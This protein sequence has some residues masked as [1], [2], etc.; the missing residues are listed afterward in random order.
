MKAPLPKNE[1]ERLNALHRYHILDTLPEAEFDDLTFLAAQ[2]CRTPI[3]LVNF[4]DADRQWSKSK[5]GLDIPETSRDVSF[6]AH[7]ILQPDLFIVPDATADERFADNPLVT[8]EPHIRF[9]AAAPLLTPDGYA[10]GTLCVIDRRTRDLNDEQE[11]ALRALS[12]QVVRQLEL[13]RHAA[14]L[15]STIAER[16]QAEEKYHGIFENAVE[17]IYQT[18]LE[19]RIRSANPALARILGYASPEEFM[20]SLTDIARQIYVEPDRRA[21]FMRLMQEQGSVSGF[22]SQVYRKDGSVIWISENARAVRDTEGNVLYYEGFVEDITERK[23][24]DR[25]KNEFISTVSHELRT[26]LTA[27][28]GALGLIAG[29]VAGEIPAQARAMI[30]I[31]HKNSERLVR[32]INEIL[33]IERIESGHVELDLRPVELMPLIEQALQANQP[34]GEQFGIR[35]VLDAELPGAKVE[36]D[37]D[38]LMQVMTHLLANAAKFSPPNGTVRVAVA[39]RGEERDGEHGGAPRPMIRVTVTDQGPG[40]P[41]EFREHLFQK[42]GQA[43]PSATRQQGDTGLG[44]SISKAI[45]EKLGGRIGFEMPGE[46]GTIFYVDLPEWPQANAEWRT[47]KPESTVPRSDFRVP[48]SSAPRIL[49]CEDD[50]DIAAVFS[51]LLQQK[52]FGSDIAASAEE[53]RQLLEHNRYHAM[54]LDL[55]LPDEDGILFIRELRESERTRDLPIIVIS[56]EAEL[57]RDDINSD[58]FKVVDWLQKPVEAERFVAAVQRATQQAMAQPRVLHIEDNPDVR[59]V[60]AAILKDTAQIVGAANLQ[61]AMRK[62]EQQTFDLIILEPALPDGSGLQLLPLLDEQQRT[63]AQPRPPVVLFASEQVAG[64][65]APGIAAELLKSRT[66]NQELKETII[67]LLARVG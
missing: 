17:G 60:V 27:I 64:G 47:W 3:S 32:L 58:E 35:F 54:T 19:G 21:Q 12:R 23:N 52:G 43:D 7:T 8:S 48:T 14:E 20:I 42:F 26:P 13:R 18:T 59:R 10:L 62:L 33:D 1:A 31:A 65:N 55:M 41:Q 45:V 67:S 63:T 40:I 56:V 24:I 34:Y 38:W 16:Q 9:Y 61:A 39:R 66:S 44:L 30:D 49:I 50:P 6:C 37:S 11:E 51:A 15:A 4:V 28:R 2:L 22:E 46:G 5:L 36:A 57:S 29:G 53:A 25:M